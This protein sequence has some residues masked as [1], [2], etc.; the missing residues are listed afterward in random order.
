MKSFT[1]LNRSFACT[2][3]YYEQGD[4]ETDEYVKKIGQRPITVDVLGMLHFGD[5]AVYCKY[6]PMSVLK[7]DRGVDFK[8]LAVGIYF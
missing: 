4:C 5:F 7:K 3:N 2:N 1:C 6:S 8:S